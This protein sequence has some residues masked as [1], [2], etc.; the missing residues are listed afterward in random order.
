MTTKSQKL[1]LLEYL[2]EHKDDIFGSLNP[3]RTAKSKVAHWTT[4]TQKLE[5]MGYSGGQDKLKNQVI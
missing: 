4:I 5:E 2:S 1:V 3:T